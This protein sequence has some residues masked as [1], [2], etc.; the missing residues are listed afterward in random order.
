MKSPYQRVPCLQRV[1]GSNLAY[2]WS[3]FKQQ[4]A[5][6]ELAQDLTATSQEKRAAS[7]F[8]LSI[9]RVNGEVTLHLKYP[10]LSA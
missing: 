7:F 3:R 10:S 1:N 2:D 9:A 8:P 4:F 5:N 6:Y